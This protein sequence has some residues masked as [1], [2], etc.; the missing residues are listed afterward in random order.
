MLRSSPVELLTAMLS[1]SGL[2]RNSFDGSVAVVGNGPIS[3]GDRRTIEAHGVVV[4]FNDANYL[5]A[6]EKT[7]LRVV[8]EPTA[9]SPKVSIDAPIWSISPVES[10]VPNTAKLATPV[11]ESQY[12]GD[13]W[14]S[15]NSVIFPSCSTC[16]SCAQ[17]GT[18]AGPSTGAAAISELNELD[19][20]AKINVFGMNWAGA[21]RI[22]IDF[23]NKTL[24]HNCC[25]KCV[26]HHTQSS[27]YG[28]GLSV[29]GLLL[30]VFGGAA[31]LSCMTGLVLET[32]APRKK[33]ETLPLLS[34]KLS[35][36]KERKEGRLNV[37]DD[38]VN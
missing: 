18:F 12:G 6:G 27:Y 13:N 30:V 24:V 37:G 34:M 29:L 17:S 8:R 19:E 25:Q 23:E 1:A 5:R 15:S 32:T 36:E 31:L 16:E 4:R 28:T 38:E 22:H 11:Y 21:A 20:I 33:T 2:N 9:L 26:F 10:F 35:M 7:T 14:I 3:E